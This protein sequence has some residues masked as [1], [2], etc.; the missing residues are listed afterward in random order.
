MIHANLRGDINFV[1]F[2]SELENITVKFEILVKKNK[3]MS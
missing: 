2:E 1:S 3:K